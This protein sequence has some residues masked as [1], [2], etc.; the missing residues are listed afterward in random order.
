[1]GRIIGAVIFAAFVLPN[2]T[3]GTLHAQGRGGGGGFRGGG[4]GASRGA[5]F[6]NPGFG[7][8]VGGHP[9]IGVSPGVRT[10]PSPV[11]P[12][13]N[14]VAPMPPRGITG[15][16]P[17][18]VGRPSFGFN[19]NKG[20][21]SSGFL[22]HTKPFGRP[23]RPFGSQVFGGFYSPFLYSPGYIDPSYI[24][25]GY[26]DPGYVAPTY[27][28]QVDQSNADLQYQVQ[29]LSEEVERLRQE[30]EQQQQQ[31]LVILPQP[32]PA[33]P[34]APVVPPTPT[35]LVFRNGQR[36]SIQNF[37]IVGQTLWILDGGITSKIPLS[38]LNLQATQDENRGKG[39]R[40]PL[41]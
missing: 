26:V 7:I 3:L 37:A 6:G 35:T 29:A 31:P 16:P 15:A 13:T 23:V 8:G 34:P 5:G 1:M 27:A 22:G 33:A 39:I 18:F 40:F 17:A 10:M 14:P 20:F 28:P 41:P 4:P 32:T 30:Q 19:G 36:T 2:M 24:N 21:G 38:E 25:P 9:G 11:T 12:M